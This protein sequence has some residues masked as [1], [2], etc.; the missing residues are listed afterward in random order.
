MI[1][2]QPVGF[3]FAR[4]LVTRSGLTP[5][6]FLHA[7]KEL[8]K[9]YA[10]ITMEPFLASYGGIKYS[11]ILEIKYVKAGVKPGDAEIGPLKA[12]AAEQLQN[13]GIDEKFK[14]NIEKTSLIKLVLIF[15]GHDLIYMD[16]VD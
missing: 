14:K 8:N 16:D 1:F 15:S 10:D 2:F 11:Y 6:N 4:H 5:K 3:Y 7:E 9:G 13:Y 12:G